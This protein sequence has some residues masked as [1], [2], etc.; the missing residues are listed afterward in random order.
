MNLDNPRMEWAYVILVFISWTWTISQW[1]MAFRKGGSWHWS[2]ALWLT[3]KSVFFTTA[4]CVWWFNW[5]EGDPWLERAI[6]TLV[7]A[8]I[9]VFIH[10]L[11]LDD[12]SES[13]LEND[14]IERMEQRSEVSNRQL[15]QDR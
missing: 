3:A 8:H 12:L 5:T 15:P 9:V 1:R 11:R 2:T 13:F 7:I 6:Y 14:S 10:W 4:A